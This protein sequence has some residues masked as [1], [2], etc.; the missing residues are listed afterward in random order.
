MEDPTVQKIAKILSE[1]SV[2]DGDAEAR[3]EFENLTVS[4]Q[5]EMLRRSRALE[6]GLPE[7]ATWSDIANASLLEKITA[8]EMSGNDISVESQTLEYIGLFPHAFADINRPLRAAE[9]G[10]PSDATWPTIMDEYEKAFRKFEKDKEG[11]PPDSMYG[12]FAW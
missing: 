9:V 8:E 12:L 10:L 1:G 7:T 3:N 11:I 6:M 4:Q 2:V 5:A